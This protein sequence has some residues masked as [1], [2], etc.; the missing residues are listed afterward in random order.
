MDEP[1][2][3][4]MTA[5]SLEQALAMPY[6]TF[7]LGLEGMRVLRI[8]PPQGDPNRYVGRLVADE[9]GMRSY[10]VG[11]N[12]GKE[13]VTLNLKAPEGRAL[14]HELVARLKP[15]VFCTN[16]L[17]SKYDALGI[18]PDTLRALHPPLI[19]C[20][21]SGFGPDRPEPAYDPMVQA[22]TGLLH[23]TGEADGDPMQVGV[24]L[25][26]L[27][28]ANEAYAQ[29]LKA[30]LRRERTGE[31]A[32]LDV[33][34]ARVTLS[35]MA[36]KLVSAA[37]GT[38]VSRFGNTHRFFSPV[39]VFRTADGWVMIAVG[40]DRQWKELVR[41]PGFEH[42]D[43]PEYE[44][45]AGRIGDVRNLNAALAEV[46]E[47][48]PTAEISKRFQTAGI[49]I[50]PVSTVD[51]LFDDPFLSGLMLAARDPVHG[52]R[53]PLAPSPFEE[54]GAPPRPLLP[55]APRLGEH[56]DAVWGGTL[57]RDVAALRTQG[58]I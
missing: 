17:P 4:G 9:E 27:G 12:A 26:D 44:R 57:G 20:G 50:S 21:L 22:Y 13:S 5:L 6:C 39:N 23:V 18:D 10:F 2:L 58:V 49:P 19:W 1:L 40:N 41:L 38:D 42:L 36:T 8:E 48:R 29:I 24:P 53:V 15:D 33:S 16:Q 52:T 3:K 25:A 56:N 35:F 14:L 46:M 11:I 43:R 30:L 37:L 31:G 32:R 51:D 54:T 47:G 45:N 7:R 55:W 34:M 28:A